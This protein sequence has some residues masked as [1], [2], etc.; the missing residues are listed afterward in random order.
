MLRTEESQAKYEA[1]KATGA[2]DEG[3]VLCGKETLQ[4]FEHWTV[5]ENIFPYDKIAKTHHMAIPK[6]HVT[7][8]ELSEEELKELRT[9]KET[10][11]HTNYDFI[12]EATYRMKSIP[13][14]FH[15]HL[16]VL[17]DLGGI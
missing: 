15:I 12:I 8:L 17:K 14:H 3:C 4:P 2:L 5:I 9:I 7:E 13:G 6:R 16:I 11:F 10:Y 1:Y